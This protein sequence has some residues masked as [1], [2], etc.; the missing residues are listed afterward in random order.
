MDA[1]R[2]QM[3]RLAP[4][5]ICFDEPSVPAFLLKLY[6]ML[7]DP[8]TDDIISWS[9]S[10]ESFVVHKPSEFSTLMLPQFFKHSNFQS[11]V[12]QLNLYG[13]HKLKQAPNFHEFAHGLFKRGFKHLLKEIKRKLPPTPN[14]KK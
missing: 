9:Q 1:A 4:Q 3:A 5:Q 2:N 12:R 7:E 6:T 14:T 13:F 11:F 8:N 10:G